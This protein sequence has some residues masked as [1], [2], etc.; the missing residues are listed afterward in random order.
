M[1][2]SERGI[3]V[4][5]KEGKELEGKGNNCSSARA[6]TKFSAYMKGVIANDAASKKRRSRVQL[7]SQVS[8]QNKAQIECV[9][10]DRCWSIGYVPTG[11]ELQTK[12][13]AC[14]WI[15]V[16]RCARDDR[17]EGRKLGG[18]RSTLVA[19]G[20]V[21]GTLAESKLLIFHESHLLRKQNAQAYKQATNR[22]HYGT[23]WVAPG[24]D[25]IEG[26]T[27]AKR[28]ITTFRGYES[29]DTET[30]GRPFPQLRP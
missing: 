19:A 20:A 25:W 9:L 15:L 11:C 21:E 4:D 7:H 6:F 14:A 1:V 12:R 10:F 16:F 26:V 5:G 18:H 2:D 8:L 3:K 27:E 30:N 29:A 24:R 22:K 17:I 13:V 28:D 23:N